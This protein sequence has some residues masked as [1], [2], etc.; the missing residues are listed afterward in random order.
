MEITHHLMSTCLFFVCEF[1]C[2]LYALSHRNDFCFFLY[3]QA[4]VKVYDFSGQI[5]KLESGNFSLKDVENADDTES[6]RFI[7][8]ICSA[9][10]VCFVSAACFCLKSTLVCC[11]ERFL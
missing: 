7:T 3:L 10:A 2:S 9:R 6:V 1:R 5:K 11:V 8:R 4:K